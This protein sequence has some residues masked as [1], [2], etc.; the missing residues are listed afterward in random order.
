[1]MGKV[2]I[3]SG[4]VGAGKSAVARELVSLLPGSVAIIEGDKFWSFIA[5][6][7]KSDWRE[8]FHTIMRSMTAA[9]IPFVRMEYDVVL[10]FSVPPH[11]LGFARKIL[12]EIHLEY[13]VLQPSQKVC[14][15]RAAARPEGT[16]KDYSKYSEFYLLFNEYEQYRIA[17][18]TAA[19]ADLALRIKDGLKTGKFL[20]P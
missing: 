16:I 3:I 9:T 1:M 11:F 8:N 10:D 20:V 12:K 18:D 15:A 2:I 4:P 14:A 5:K 19:P 6:S 7:E 13:V 17:D